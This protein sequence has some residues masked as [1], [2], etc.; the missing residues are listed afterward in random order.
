M[1]PAMTLV[2]KCGTNND[3]ARTTR[4]TVKVNYKIFSIV[5][6]Q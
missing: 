1:P 3:I 5:E 2:A 4:D 6:I